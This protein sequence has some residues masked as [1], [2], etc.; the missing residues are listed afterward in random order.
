MSSNVRYYFAVLYIALG[1]ISWFPG[2]PLGFLKRILLI[3]TVLLFRRLINPFKAEGFSFFLFSLGALFLSMSFNPDAIRSSY[4]DLIIG[5]IENYIFFLI[6]YSALSKCNFNKTFYR[7]LLSFIIIASSL[8]VLNYLIGIPNWYAPSQYAIESEQLLENLV[9]EKQS[10]YKT[11]FSWSRNGWGNTIALYLP[12]LLYLYPFSKVKASIS[13]ILIFLSIFICGTRNGFLAALIPLVLYIYLCNKN[14]PVKILRMSF[15]FLLILLI[16]SLNYNTVLQSLR[17][18]DGDI[19]SGRLAQY[20]LIP[21]M[22]RDMGFWGLGLNET[23]SYIYKAVGEIHS[24]HN[25]FFNMFIEN[26]FLVGLSVGIIMFMS[27]GYFLK[28][29]KSKE[30]FIRCLGLV[31]LSGLL[32]TLFEPSMVFGFLGGSTIWWFSFGFLRALFK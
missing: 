23:Q 27:F 9:F 30:A 19:S 10:L 7:I 6:G 12:F 28:A 13:Y 22:I 18:D 20:A 31:L 14:N 21:Q 11:G 25:T 24:L 3:I 4:V 2:V 32:T 5:F 29:I 1:P 26:G 8:T 16:I 15:V 17:L